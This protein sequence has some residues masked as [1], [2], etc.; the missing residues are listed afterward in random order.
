VLVFAKGHGACQGMPTIGCFFMRDK[1]KD[2]GQCP[3]SCSPQWKAA[4]L[5]RHDLNATGDLAA[6]ALATIEGYTNDLSFLVH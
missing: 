1:L 5:H 3:S 4:V 2:D 6:H